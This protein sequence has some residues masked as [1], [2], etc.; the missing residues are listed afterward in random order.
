[1]AIFTF[2]SHIFPALIYYYLF[3]ISERGNLVQLE[4]LNKA[5]SNN[6]EHLLSIYLILVTILYA[7]T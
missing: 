6:S 3:Q 7:L 4:S 1:M 2:D 5:I